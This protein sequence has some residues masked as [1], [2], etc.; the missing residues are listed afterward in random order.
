MLRDLIQAR[1]I[2][3]DLHFF[4]SLDD[5]RRIRRMRRMQRM[6]V[7]SVAHLGQHF[8]L[9]FNSKCRGT[10]ASSGQPPGR[11]HTHTP[12]HT[13]TDIHTLTHTQEMG[14]TSTEIN[15][16]DYRIVAVDWSA[17]PFNFSLCVC[18]C[19]CVRSEAQCHTHT[20]QAPE[21]LSQIST[22]LSQQNAATISVTF[23]HFDRLAAPTIPPD[24]NYSADRLNG[25]TMKL[26]SE[27]ISVF[28]SWF[29]FCSA[30]N[31]GAVVSR[32]AH[33]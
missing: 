20:Q 16:I 26:E 5:Q 8:S 1:I 6:G 11:Q 7:Q 12:G 18:V 19:E 24:E 27:K 3:A 21:A 31:A 22:F 17:L 4:F 15:T 9:D 23:S 32:L 29:L 2:T 14:T 10:E 13:H 25:G 28:F 30:P 33:W